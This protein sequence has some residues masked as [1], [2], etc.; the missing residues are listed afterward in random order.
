M[1]TFY[2]SLARR[3]WSPWKAAKELPV[4]VEKPMASEVGI[5]SAAQRRGAGS[6]T[7]APRWFQGS[8]NEGFKGRGA[9][10]LLQAEFSLGVF[11]T[12]GNCKRTSTTLEVFCQLLFSS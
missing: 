7:E 1:V 9:K 8:R 11:K 10:I 2:A 5:R 4:V 12:P 6:D 3:R